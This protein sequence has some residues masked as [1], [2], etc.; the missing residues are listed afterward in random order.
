[1]SLQCFRCVFFRQPLDL[2]NAHSAL[3]SAIGSNSRWI[4]GLGLLAAGQ[5][6][7]MACTYA[8]QFIM[9][10]KFITSTLSNEL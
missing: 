9:E 2:Y 10:G 8:G 6:S 1:M 7:T 3:E 5:C 4:W